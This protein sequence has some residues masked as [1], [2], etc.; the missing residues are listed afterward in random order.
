MNAYEVKWKGCRG[1]GYIGGKTEEDARKRFKAMF[2]N[3]KLK[4]IEFSHEVRTK[5]KKKD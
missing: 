4:A 3:L 5:K 2:P 1:I